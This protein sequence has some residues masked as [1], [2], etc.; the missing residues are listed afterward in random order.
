M[1]KSK[2]SRRCAIGIAT[3]VLVSACFGETAANASAPDRYTSESETVGLKFSGFDVARAAAHGYSVRTD[4]AGW[5]YA[6][7]KDNPIGDMTNATPRFNPVSGETRA[8]DAVGDDD[9]HAS[10]T[11][12]GDCG[13]ATLTL[14]TR[15]SGYTAYNLKPGFGGAT[16]HEWKIALSAQTG[17]TIIDRSGLPPVPGVSLNWG[18][19]FTYAVG[20]RQG[21]RVYGKVT[22][23]VVVTTLGTCTAMS[24]TDEYYD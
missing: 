12:Y 21:T 7:P 8:L 11:V 3:V 2:S 23:G 13:S 22:P 19:N 6:V 16:F 1:S 10:G 18:T 14:Y 9:A 5:Q 24:P 15:T 20:A 17:N 4:S